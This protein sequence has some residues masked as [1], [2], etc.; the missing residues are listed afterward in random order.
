MVSLMLTI[1]SISDEK[2]IQTV[3]DVVPGRPKPSLGLP[4]SWKPDPAD[5]RPIYAQVKD[6]L[7]TRVAQGELV[8]GAAI[9]DQAVLAA[10]LGIS[11]MTV[12]RALIELADEGVLNRRRGKGTFVSLPT[13]PGAAIATRLRIAIVTPLDLTHQRSP[14]FYQRILQAMLRAAEDHGASISVRRDVRPY[15]ESFAPLASARDLAGIA[16][17]GCLDP[18][19]IEAAVA[20]GRPTVLID[21]VA[22][23]SLPDLDEV[24]HHDEASA[25]DAVA[26]LLRLGH[27]RIAM[28][29]AD[30]ASLFFAQRVAGYRLAHA[31]ARVPVDEAL[32]LIGVEPASTN[33]YAATRSLIAA[34]P[35]ITALFCSTD[36]MAL[37]AMAALRDAGRRI[38]DDTSIIGFGDIGV[39]SSPALSSVRIPMERLGRDAVECLFQRLDD[40]DRPAQKRLVEPEWIPRAS[41]GWAPL[42]RVE[43]SVTP[44]RETRA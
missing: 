35:D 21:S 43:A 18:T 8:P 39:F 34:R 13:A 2:V 38:P 36:E 26:E 42:N 20:T 4:M 27:R 30:T 32:V 9:R 41:S 23:A 17:L 6:W 31:E 15:A 11:D 37:G 44:P 3:S 19:M 28:L 40:P 33:A 12:R 1:G 10:D 24:N 14:L 16:L 29:S 25:H 5:S 7:R 22:P